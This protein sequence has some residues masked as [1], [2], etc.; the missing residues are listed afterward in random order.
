M[1]TVG[2][3]NFHVAMGLLLLGSTFLDRAMAGVLPAWNP[4]PVGFV[5]L[6]LGLVWVAL[7]A[8]YRIRRLDEAL[9][10]AEARVERLERRLA[11]Q[12]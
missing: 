1:V 3:R 7:F 10:V 8:G 12:E 4:P 5:T 2:E 9:R 11:E 6:V